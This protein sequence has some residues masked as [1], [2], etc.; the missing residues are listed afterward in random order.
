[1]VLFQRG[2]GA[3][4]TAAGE[5]AIAHTRRVLRMLDTLVAEADTVAGPLRVAAF[6]RS[7]AQLCFSWPR[8]TSW[9]HGP[10]V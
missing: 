4:P 7:A 5:R 9:A 2:Q 8:L 10:R 6:R 1:M 3:T